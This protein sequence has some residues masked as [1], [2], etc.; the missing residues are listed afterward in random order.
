MVGD[1]LSG[2]LNCCAP[3]KTVQSIG[4]KNDAFEEVAK[5]LPLEQK[6]LPLA[7]GTGIRGIRFARTGG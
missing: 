7:H 3:A 4:P 1:L 2:S 5:P 6:R